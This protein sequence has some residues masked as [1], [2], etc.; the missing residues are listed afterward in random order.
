MV[1]CIL[2]YRNGHT[3]HHPY[4]RRLESFRVQISLNTVRTVRAGLDCPRAGGGGVRQAVEPS[5]PFIIIII[6]ICNWVVTR[7]QLLFY[8]YTKFY[9]C[10]CPVCTGGLYGGKKA[11]TR[12]CVRVKYGLFSTYC[13]RIH[14]LHMLVANKMRRFLLWSVCT[15]WSGSGC[16]L[17]NG[18]NI[19][20]TAVGWLLLQRCLHCAEPERVVP[21]RFKSFGM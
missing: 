14:Q 1:P 11:T 5:K 15:T 16:G 6:I 10:T 3:R 7:W 17:F 20:M 9:V 21:C 13:T 19:A 18:K 12:N 8:M 4:S 2:A